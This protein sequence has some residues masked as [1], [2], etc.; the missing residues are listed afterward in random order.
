[1]Q[2]ALS[3][4]ALTVS[5]N[6]VTVSQSGGN[7]GGSTLG[8]TALL[9]PPRGNAGVP[10]CLADSG[11]TAIWGRRRDLWTHQFY[12]YY[13]WW[14]PV[15]MEHR[16]AT[17]TSSGLC[18]LHFQFDGA[19]FELFVAGTDLQI[20]LI[21]DGQ[22]T[23]PRQITNAWSGGVA[24]SRLSQP[25]SF[26]KFDFGSKASRKVS[27]YARSSQG[28]AALAV[29]AGDS[30]RAWDRSAEACMGT[31]SDSYGQVSS[32]NWGQ[33]GPFWEAAALLGIP[34]QDM[35]S[36]GGTGY[37]VNSVN[38]NSGDSFG[39]RIANSARLMP[40]LF[41]TAGGINDNNWLALPPYASADAARAGFYSAVAAYFR[42]LRAAMP[43]TVLV[44]VGP[45]TPP[46]DPS[47]DAVVQAKV[48]AILGSLQAVSGPW[49]FIDNVTDYWLGSSGASSPPSGQRWQTGKGWVGNEAHDGGNSDL[50]IADGTHP[51]ELGC[52]YLAQRLSAY[53]RAALPT[54]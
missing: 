30:I 45:W 54:L 49:V 44:A 15:S 53:L 22:Y 20:T 28:P 1:L 39:A 19:A 32:K 41:L 16:A 42:D 10:N 27:V 21:A 23:T 14:A 4:S 24:G 43:G 31:M 11:V 25:N 35:N 26:V 6:T 38:L 5:S 2:A 33:G 52:S 18:G 29:E 37:A 12:T 9:V 47:P 50:F 40:D 46:G 48:A 8:D 3:S 36:I 17:S 13:D 7:A 51:N 34:H